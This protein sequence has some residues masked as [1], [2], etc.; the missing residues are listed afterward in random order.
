MKAQIFSNCFWIYEVSLSELI[1][2]LELILSYANFC[3]LKVTDSH[4]SPYGYSKLW[5]LSESHLAVHSF[6]EEQTVYVELSSCVEEK[7]HIFSTLLNEWVTQNN[8]KITIA[9]K[10]LYLATP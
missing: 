2:R 5:L 10:N 7:T 6:P 1:E 4:F 8:I 3:V 9:N